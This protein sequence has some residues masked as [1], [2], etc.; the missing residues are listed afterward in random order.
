[1]LLK[2]RSIILFLILL[3]MVMFGCDESMPAHFSY[4]TTVVASVDGKN[5]EL[6]DIPYTVRKEGED[7]K[8]IFE[9]KTYNSY[10]HKG[11]AGVVFFGEVPPSAVDYQYVLIDNV[12][13]L[14]NAQLNGSSPYYLLINDSS[15][16][17]CDTNYRTDVKVACKGFEPDNTCDITK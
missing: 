12:E 8:I 3:S 11:A 6:G 13:E 16:E 9:E 17:G 7:D 5:V 15:C 10:H 1:M 14:Y 2:N 4:S